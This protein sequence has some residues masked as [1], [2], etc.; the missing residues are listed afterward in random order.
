[1][2]APR[3]GNLEARG[4]VFQHQTGLWEPRRK[5]AETFFSMLKEIFEWIKDLTGKVKKGLREIKEKVC[6]LG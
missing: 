3:G 4:K 6:N 1:M 2:W 5:G